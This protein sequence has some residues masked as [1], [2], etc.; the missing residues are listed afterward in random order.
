MQL[1][2]MNR[3]QLLEYCTQLRYCP[4][5]GLRNQTAARLENKLIPQDYA[6]LLIDIGNIHALN[7]SRGW[8][9]TNSRLHM[10]VLT[11]RHYDLAFRWGGDEFVAIVPWN[12]AEG[13]IRRLMR[14]LCKQDM[15]A[16]IVKVRTSTSLKE[17]FERADESLR[18][19]KQWLETTGR[20][21]G[22]NEDYRR[23][24]NSVI[25][26]DG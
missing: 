11:L 4:D 17:S 15:Y 20:K 7:H 3:D 10:S 24:R 21:P 25:R 1:N 26:K 19:R 8:S 18:M 23:L 16:V 5:T 9:E 12:D 14:N 13:L 22:R 6:L 2:D